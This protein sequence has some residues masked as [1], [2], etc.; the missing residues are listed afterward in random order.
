[1]H[2]SDDVDAFRL[3]TIQQAVGEL[4]NEKTPEPATKRRARRRRLRQLFVGALNRR[5]EVQTE[6]FLWR[7]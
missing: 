3:D 6:A 1:M 7:S 2:D 5:D 4:R